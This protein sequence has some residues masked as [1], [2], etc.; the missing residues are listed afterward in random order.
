[1]KAKIE[2]RVMALAGI[3]QA[4][5][6]VSHAANNGMLS[7]NSLESSLSSIF[8]TSPTD[9]LEVYGGTEGVSLG[10]KLLHEILVKLRLVE[11]G[12]LF[13]YSMSL[14]GLARKLASQ[15]GVLQEL[16]RKISYIDDHRQVVDPQLLNA[17]V[18]AGLADLY[19]D[20]IGQIGHKIQIVGKRQHL[21]NTS[22]VNRIRALLLAGIRSAVLWQQ[23]GGRRRH[24]LFSYGA[25]VAAL[26]NI[27]ININNNNLNNLY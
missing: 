21:E 23:L 9:A 6:L 27:K 17:S 1:M 24:L 14:V 26:E 12:E 19:Q 7:Q 3:L 25:I 8:V 15:Q 16:R 13:R 2:E 20:T 4:A 11:H 18:I 5:A 22:N 10:V